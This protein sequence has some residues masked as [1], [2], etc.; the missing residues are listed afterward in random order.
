MS[1]KEKNDPLSAGFFTPK[2]AAAL[3][4]IPTRKIYGWVNG[5]RN[6]NAP[7][8]IDRDFK[9]YSAI[10]F[11]DLMELRFVEYFRS[12]GVSMQ[13]IRLSANRLRKDWKVSH[14]F[15]L[16]KA[17]YLTDR[18]KIFAQI[19]KDQ[20]DKK[21]WDLASG[22]HEIWEAIEAEIAKGVEF[23]PASLLA[24]AWRPSANIVIDPRMAFGRPVV[25]SCGIPTSAMFSHW[26]AEGR[27]S[28]VARWFRVAERDVEAAISF[29]LQLAA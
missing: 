11:L 8:V 28:A 12:Q 16:S 29:E 4:G 2:L 14:P 21:T 19:A 3:V 17:R 15:A 1:A 24:S 18:R 25:E 20:G 22:Q 27:K 13:T 10:S 23:D 7:A 5:Y 26:L 9:G 6:S